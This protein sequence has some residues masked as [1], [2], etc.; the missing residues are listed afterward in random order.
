VL[1]G[2]AGE[3]RSLR[4]LAGG[5]VLVERSAGGGLV[6]PADE[7]TMLRGHRLLVPVG[8][9]PLQPSRQRLHGRAIAQ[10]L[11][12]LARSDPHP[13]LLLLNVRHSAKTPATR[14]ERS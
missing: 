5:R 13:L 3:A 14:A 7:L 2:D 10:V 12:P 6:D 9:R 4:L 1:R 11:E 8:Y